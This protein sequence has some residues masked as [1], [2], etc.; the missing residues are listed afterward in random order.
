MI[1]SSF[2]EPKLA[3]LID[4]IIKD[5]ANLNQKKI[6][7]KFPNVAADLLSVNNDTVFNFFSKKG[8]GDALTHLDRLTDC[9][10]QKNHQK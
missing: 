10:D 8:E 5:H 3:K 4:Y 9:L 2:D 1:N 6:A 7:F